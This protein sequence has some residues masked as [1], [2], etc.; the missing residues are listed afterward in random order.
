MNLRDA[1]SGR[2]MWESSDDISKPDKEHEGEDP[3]IIPLDS[4]T[5]FRAN[6]LLHYFH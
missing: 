4:R 1:D 3:S 2:L 6:F 5:R